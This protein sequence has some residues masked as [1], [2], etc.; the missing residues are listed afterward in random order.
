MALTS[1]TINKIPS[2]T[3]TLAFFYSSLDCKIARIGGETKKQPGWTSLA[4]KRRRPGRDV[5]IERRCR[6]VISIWK[7]STRRR[8]VPPG[9]GVHIQRRAPTLRRTSN[10]VRRPSILPPTSRRRRTASRRITRR[11][12]RRTASRQTGKFFP[13]RSLVRYDVNGL[14]QPI[15]ARCASWPSRRRSTLP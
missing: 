9:K 14:P 15:R 4:V 12:M 2:E 10:G 5:N 7:I 11:P 1:P 6:S 3:D 8:T 13:T